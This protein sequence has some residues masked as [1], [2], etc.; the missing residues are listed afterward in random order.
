MASEKQSAASRANGAKSRGPTTP[1]GKQKSSR[2]SLRH[3]MLARTIVLDGESRDRFNQL[4]NALTSELNPANTIETQLVREMAIAHW[5]QMRSWNL[6]TASISM[7]VNKQPVIVDSTINQ[8]EMRYDRQFSRA[9][10]RL[11]AYRAAHTKNVETN[12]TSN[13]LFHHPLE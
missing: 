10:D 6:G 9:L 5:R 7:E 2:N 12:P 4:H 13:S 8:F 11:N 3:G 1:A